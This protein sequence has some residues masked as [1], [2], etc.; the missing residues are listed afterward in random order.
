[1]AT[2]G[3]SNDSRPARGD[4]VQH[5]AVLLDDLL[6]GRVEELLL[7]LEV[8]V[9]RPETD[10][11]GLGDLLDAHPG[12]VAGGQQLPRRRHQ[13]RPRPG[14]APVQAAGSNACRHGHSV[15]DSISVLMT[16]S[17]LGAFDR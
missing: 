14:L 4:L 8:V 11:G 7:G 5:R 3:S 12:R 17:V 13:R 9:E 16:H 2:S 6:H 15:T 10:V 1:M